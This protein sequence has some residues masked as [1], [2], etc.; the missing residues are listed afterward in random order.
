MD[1]KVNNF[2]ALVRARSQENLKS[3]LLLVDNGSFSIAI[4]LL[5]QELDSLIRVAFL[6]DNGASSEISLSLIND[7][8]EG[9]QWKRTTK[10]NKKA[11]ITDREMINIASSLGG[12]VEI[13]YSFGCKL[14][15]LS[16]IHGYKT[17]NPQKNITDKDKKEIIKYLYGYHGYPYG[18]IEQIHIE[19]YL[20]KVMKK[21]VENVE[22][23][24]KKI[25]IENNLI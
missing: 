11:R 23:Y 10:K 4:G 5:R 24:I 19:E 12:W 3:L 22:Y 7:L 17:N 2:C 15:H 1:E 25:E 9:K 14:I 13:I 6:C 21:L 8:L 16:D 18:D 20:P